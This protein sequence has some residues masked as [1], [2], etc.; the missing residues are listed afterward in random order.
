MAIIT[1]YIM[2]R[3]SL[4][5]F[6]WLSLY[7]LLL[8]K[9]FSYICTHVQRSGCT[10]N[11]HYSQSCMC[12]YYMCCHNT[13][14]YTMTICYIHHQGDYMV[15]LLASHVNY[16]KYMWTCV[17]VHAQIVAIKRKPLLIAIR[18]M[19]IWQTP[20]MTPNNFQSPNYVLNNQLARAP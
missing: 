16:L 19:W 13:Y 11:S 10:A 18:G 9:V 14:S 15:D 1:L 3:V 12:Y 7:F 8:S 4:L 17:H 20:P 2:A 6:V 5:Q